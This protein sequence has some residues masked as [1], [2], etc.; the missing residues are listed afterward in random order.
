MNLKISTIKNLLKHVFFFFLSL[1]VCLLGFSSQENLMRKHIPQKTILSNGLTL[2]YE[3]DKSFPTTFLQILIKGGIKD[4]PEG[5]EGLAYLTTRLAV[6][7]PDRDK[8]QEMMKQAT[9][10]SVRCK[11]DYS[12]INLKC[13]TENLQ[14][15]LKV[16]TTI[17]QKPI[18]SG[19]RINRIKDYM[20]HFGKSEED[21]PVTAGKKSN[22][23]SFFGPSTYG[24]SVY[25][26]QESLKATNKKDIEGFYLNHFAANNMIISVSSDLDDKLLIEMIQECFG[27]FP[28]TQL[29]ESRPTEPSLPEDKNLYFEKDAKQSFVSIAFP[30]PRLTARNFALAVMVENLLGKGVGSKLWSL[31]STERLAY[32]VNSQAIYMKGG[33]IL[34]AYLETKNE[35]KNRALESLRQVLQLL[36]EKGISEEEHQATQVS[37]KANFLRLNET[38]E[39]RISSFSIFEALGL[40]HEFFFRFFTEVNSISLEE[41]N[42]FLKEILNPEKGVEVI[43]GPKME[44]K[45]PLPSSL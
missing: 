7:I 43:I 14:E 19:I 33:G 10:I 16:M 29:E 9:R 27:K 41:I 24:G 5:K 30:L 20:I 38:K 23:K 37:S 18:F 13:L 8:I 25:G 34:Q 39:A 17:I 32:N 26:T 22:F 11:G 31:R 3:V 4:V 6:D 2:I 28:Q 35:N 42:I 40:G 36:Y 45:A 44:E 15:S 21:D 1:T 12:L